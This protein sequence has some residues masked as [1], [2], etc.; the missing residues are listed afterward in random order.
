MALLAAVA[1]A[2]AC[3]R[4]A[5]SPVLACQAQLRLA[6]REPTRAVEH[7]EAAAAADPLAAEPWRQLAA[8]E[9]ERW[10]QDP[11]DEAFRRLVQANNKALELAPN[12]APTWLAAGDWYVQAFMKA[13]GQGKRPTGDAIAKAVEAY[14]HAVELYPNSAFYRA[15]L[16]E[17]CRAAGDLSG[18]R[19]EAEA[20]LRLDGLTPHVDKKL[21]AGA[22]EPSTGSAKPR[23]MKSRGQHKLGGTCGKVAINYSIQPAGGAYRR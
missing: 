8:I 14:R 21:P 19:R 10:W 23:L 20:A 9:F 11:S 4:T 13:G 7:L 6:E 1:L 15:K 22:Q 16:A 3:Y 5:Y 12:S 18:F 17:A 2:V